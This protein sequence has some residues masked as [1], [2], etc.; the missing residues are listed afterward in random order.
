VDPA[1]IT[2]AFN[3]TAAGWDGVNTPVTAPRDMGMVERAL[4]VNPH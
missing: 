1:L 2:A 3:P 4:I